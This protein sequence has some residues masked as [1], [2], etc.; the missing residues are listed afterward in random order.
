MTYF[1]LYSMLQLDN[2]SMILD[3]KVLFEHFSVTIPYGSRIAIIGHNGCG[4]S[5]MLK[6]IQDH[7]PVGLS[8]GYIPQN[9]T[10]YPELSG[11]QRFQKKL[12]EVL[13]MKPD[14]LFLDEPT[15]H[16]DIAN[17]KTLMRSLNAFLGTMIVVSHDRQWLDDDFF[18][19]FWHMSNGRVH[20]FSGKHSEYSKQQDKARENF[21]NDE[22]EL[23][24]QKKKV[25]TQLSQEQMRINRSKGDKKATQRWGDGKT[26]MDRMKDAADELEEQIYEK[27]QGLSEERAHLNIQKEIQYTFN[28]A[29]EDLND[30]AIVTVRNGSVGYGDIVLLKKLNLTLRHGDRLAIV[31]HNGSGKTTLLKAIV[32]NPTVLRTGKWIAPTQDRIGY[33]DQH[34]GLLNLDQTVLKNLRNV[35]P[36]WEFDTLRRHL[37]CFLFRKNEEVDCLAGTLSG[38]EKVRLS[39]ALISAKPPKLL[40]VDEI[41]NNLDLQTR[42][43]IIQILQKYPG[44]MIAVSH[45]EDFLKQIHVTETFCCTDRPEDKPVPLKGNKQSESS[46]KRK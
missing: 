36:N 45:D 13:H 18:E 7:I 38:G 19:T 12:K 29:P 10:E 35:V 31:G 3:H 8:F 42:A 2:L 24:L 25:N 28:I 22:L 23:S 30:Q 21:A 34:Y 4:K 14:I 32:E 33:L 17:Q 15:N 16:L 46:N 39:L 9:I 6:T 27:R 20:I 37:A 40:I 1:L 5:T 43:H 11:G 41:T 44:A 26:A